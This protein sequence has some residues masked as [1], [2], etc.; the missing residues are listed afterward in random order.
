LEFLQEAE[1]GFV[2][3]AEVNE[4]ISLWILMEKQNLI[5]IFSKFLIFFGIGISAKGNS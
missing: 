2:Q 3:M 4:G 5:K 1:D